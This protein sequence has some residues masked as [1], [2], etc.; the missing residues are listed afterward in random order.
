MQ[1]THRPT[2]V[3]VVDVDVA[4]AVPEGLTEEPTKDPRAGLV[5]S[6]EADCCH[7]LSLSWHLYG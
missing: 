6:A 3:V 5:G 4:A 2:A 7:D 1:L